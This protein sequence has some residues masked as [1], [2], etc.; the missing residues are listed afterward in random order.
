MNLLADYNLPF[1]AALLLML[2]L[3]VLQLVGLGDFELDADGDF[4]IDADVDGAEV[5]HL[6]V[7]DGLFSLIGFGRLPFMMWLAL[8]LALFA[9]VGVGVQQLAIAFFGAPLDVLLGAAGAGLLSLPVTGL[10]ARPIAAVMPKD[11]TSAVRTDELVG[12][13]GQIAT[14]TARKGYAARAQVK[15]RFGVTHNVMVEPHDGAAQLRE[16]DEI[17]LVRREG[18]TFFAVEV[19]DRRLAPAE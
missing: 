16:G 4:D 6:G 7:V 13:R 3:A 17:L 14:G 9:G 5:G 8:A 11:E 1:A 15:D 2:A 12:R 19:Q 10:V 18:E